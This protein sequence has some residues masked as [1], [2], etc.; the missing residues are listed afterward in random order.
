MPPHVS[1]VVPATFASRLNLV[2]GMRRHSDRAL[3]A[4]SGSPPLAARPFLS[5][6]R[7][8]HLSPLLLT[9]AA[10]APG[11]PLSM[12]ILNNPESPTG[13]Q[14][15]QTSELDPDTEL[16][17]RDQ[18]VNLEHDLKAARKE[19]RAAKKEANTFRARVKELEEEKDVLRQKVVEEM[20]LKKQAFDRVNRMRGAI[21]TVGDL[22]QEPL[23]LNHIRGA[24]SNPFGQ[25][26]LT[27]TS[28]ATTSAATASTTLPPSSSATHVSSSSRSA[29]GNSGRKSS[30]QAPES[31]PPEK[32]K[33]KKQSR[34]PEEQNED[35]GASGDQ[36]EK[37]RDSKKHGHADYSCCPFPDCDFPKGPN[38]PQRWDHMKG[39]KA[40]IKKHIASG[41]H[42]DPW[43]NQAE[44][45]YPAIA[46]ETPLT[47]D[48]FSQ[49]CRR[50]Q[51]QQ[52]KRRTIRRVFAE[53]IAPP[54]PDQDSGAE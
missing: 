4:G 27:G 48:I 24:A 17:L 9:I 5:E 35:S 54:S 49:M 38:H 2:P 1:P 22:M 52:K 12:P 25:P 29:S 40:H 19:L 10:P 16:G 21:R 34:Q 14:G 6:R 31:P 7:P 53:I 8:D 39:S 37:Q 50:L 32:K 13:S 26:L 3:S 18:I 36:Q 43:F 44:G 30:A 20:S 23:S 51:E 33:K 28:S 47:A 42:I 46:P 45:A 41:L 11:S 15:T